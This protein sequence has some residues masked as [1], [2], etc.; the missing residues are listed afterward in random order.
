MA[1]Q[2]NFN[3]KT[4]KHSF[5]SVKQKA[6]HNLGL[7][8]DGYPTSSEAIQF[9][10]LDYLV[11]KRNLFTYGDDTSPETEDNDIVM[12]WRLDVPNYYATVRTDTEQILG[13][14]G[15]DYEVVQNRDAFSFFDAIV[16][17]GDGVLY[18]TCGALGNGERIFITAKLPGYIRVGND[19][20]IEKYL[21][22]TTSHD[23][24]GSITAAFTPT[25]IVCNNT[26]HAALGNM[27]NCVKIRHTQSAQE[28]LKQAHKVMGISNAMSEQL[29]G[30]FDRWAHILIT[31]KE[32]LKLVQQAMAPS[33][34][35]LQN[36]LD[37]N[38]DEYS[39]QFLNT[40]EK[41]CEFA[42][43]HPTQQ[44]D[45]TRGTLFGAYNA[46]SGYMQNVKQYKTEEV[47]LKSILF[48]NGFTKTQTAFQLCREFERTGETQLVLN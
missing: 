20:L 24:Y 22:L 25:R 6:W 2:I 40:V 3:E 27:T 13:V 41:V 9:A 14:V 47:K 46:I 26:L 29:N 32:V 48:G 38:I 35:V 21:F 23:G 19:D 7:V 39:S 18:E 1:H 11:E 17:G 31:D 42:F 43:S 12:E 15:N 10:G 37:E 30:I 44:M 8:I 36:V 28:R 34:E 4:G 45:T 5:M 33:R 16:G